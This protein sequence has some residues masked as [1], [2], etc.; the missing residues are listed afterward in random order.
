[1]ADVTEIRCTPAAQES[2]CDTAAEGGGCGCIAGALTRDEYERH[3]T[4]AG[5]VDVETACT[6][7]RCPRSCGRASPSDGLSRN[8]RARRRSHHPRRQA[9][10]SARDGTAGRRPRG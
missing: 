7:R 1:M 4:D 9:W 6:T 3:L 5:L 2:C 10:E 8:R